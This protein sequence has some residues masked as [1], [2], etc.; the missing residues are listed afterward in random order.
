MR[1]RIFGGSKSNGELAAL[2]TALLTLERVSYVYTQHVRER[3][4]HSAFLSF[5]ELLRFRSLDGRSPL[6]LFVLLIGGICACVSCE[7]PNA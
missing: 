5:G 1:L 3:L 2:V 6:F 7:D 4:T